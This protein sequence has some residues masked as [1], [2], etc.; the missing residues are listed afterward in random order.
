MVV[1]WPGPDGGG[2]G[3]GVPGVIGGVGGGGA[4]VDLCS[5]AKRITERSEG[6]PA[7]TALI[8]RWPV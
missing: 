8:K 1:F 2:G 5:F 7:L 6:M 3:G 4:G